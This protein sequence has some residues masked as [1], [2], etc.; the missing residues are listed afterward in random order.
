MHL[1]AWEQ[2]W[3][4]VVDRHAILRTSFVWEGVDEP[5]QVVYQQVKIALEQYDWRGLSAAEQKERLQAFRRAERARDFDLSQ[6]PLMRLAVIRSD[7]DAYQFIKTYHYLLLDGWSR[8]LLWKEIFA[9][10]E[11]LCN[12]QDIEMEPLP[13]LSKLH[14]LDQTTGFIPSGKVL[15]I[16]AQK[17]SRL[18][19]LWCGIRFP[20][21]YQ[22]LRKAMSS[23]KVSYQG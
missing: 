1:S 22:A 20:E 17:A 4:R 21:I 14:R 5:L 2:A 7:E 15:E 8:A 23:K 6:A 10:Y 16:D 9:F 18:R 13:S 12:G 19:H 11:T 3:Q